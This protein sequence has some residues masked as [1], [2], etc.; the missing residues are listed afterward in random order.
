MEPSYGT[1]DAVAII[2]AVHEP[3]T[4]QPAIIGCLGTGSDCASEDLQLDPGLEGTDD[5]DLGPRFT[6]KPRL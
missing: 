6:I 4:D 5:H 2:L 1:R 3:D